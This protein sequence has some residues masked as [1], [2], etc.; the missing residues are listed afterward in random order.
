MS[1]IVKEK[2]V[3]VPGEVLAEGMEYLP[4]RGTYRLDDKI[5]AK[6]LGL[7]HVDGK[8]IKLIPL[9]GAYQPK[10]NDIII[11]KVV[12]VMMFGWRADTNSAYSSVLPVSDG[13][14]DFVEKGADLSKYHKLGD[15]ILAKIT[16]VTSQKLIDISMK[17]PGLKKLIGGRIIKVSPSKVPRVIGKA[18]SMVSMIKKATGVQITV[19]QNGVIWVLGKEPEDEIKAIESVNKIVNNSHVSGLT[20]II[21]KDLGITDDA[22]ETEA[23]DQK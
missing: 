22:V 19:G 20:D 11:A 9:S 5:I 21:K 2:D 1:L 14:T 8:V 3:V 23:G 16:N 13:T 17:G 6:R 12:D 15:Y 18:G 4:S 10:K 7:I